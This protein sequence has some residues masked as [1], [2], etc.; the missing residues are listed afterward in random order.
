MA[1]QDH[2]SADLKAAM[3]NRDS[4]TVSVL[5]MVQAELKNAQIAAGKPLEETEAVQVV[6][7]EIKKRLDTA[8]TYRQAGQPDRAETEEKEAATLSVYLPA[9]TDPTIVK[10]FL[11]EK[12]ATLRPLEPK[13]RGELI[14]AAM[15]Q[16]PGTLDGKKVADMVQALYQ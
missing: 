3:L 11:E 1:L 9:E 8:A 5:R 13:H 2:L 12:A 14:R 6:R 16:F 15:E 10:A 4:A 7:K